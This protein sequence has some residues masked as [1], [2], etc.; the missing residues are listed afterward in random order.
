M[1]S[2]NALIILL[3]LA[4][5]VAVEFHD[6]GWLFASTPYGP[7]PDEI[8]PTLNFDGTL[9]LTIDSTAK[10]K[11]IFKL[12]TV[13]DTPT[14]ESYQV[15]FDA[16]VNAPNID[17]DYGR[18]FGAGEKEN[19][20][21]PNLFAFAYD[22]ENATL[23]KPP[24]SMT[25]FSFYDKYNSLCHVHL[26]CN[27]V[28]AQDKA[29]DFYCTSPGPT[30]IYSGWVYDAKNFGNGVKENDVTAEAFQDSDWKTIH[31]YI[32][33]GECAANRTTLMIMGADTLGDKPYTWEIRNV[34]LVTDKEIPLPLDY[35]YVRQSDG[36]YTRLEKPAYCGDGEKAGTEECDGTDGVTAGWECTSACKLVPKCGDNMIVGSEVCDGTAHTVGFTCAS[37]CSKEIPV[38]GDNMVVGDEVCDGTATPTGFACSADCKTMSPICGD[39]IVVG[40]EECD[41]NNGTKAGYN[42]TSKC[43]LY[44]VLSPKEQKAMDKLAELIGESSV[45]VPSTAKMT[46]PKG[47]YSSEDFKDQAILNNRT[48]D[49]NVSFCTTGTTACEERY[50]MIEDAMATPTGMSPTDDLKGIV[51][52]Y[53]AEANNSTTYYIGFKGGTGLLPYIEM[54]TTMWIIV[55]VIGLLA[56]GALVLLLFLLGGYIYY[57]KK[58]GIQFKKLFK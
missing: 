15:E 24:I 43:T 53:K 56:L 25:T 4:S 42:C 18:D 5:A 34:R 13:Y 20:D 32:D 48:L 16:R 54:D 47:T 26:E 51:K 58:G 49:G 3:L 11:S 41:G 14:T 45:G 8:T 37:N 7:G 19:N 36:S 50:V 17:L 10:G 52:V 35:V 23:E 44:R 2:R 38:C 39:G 6:G 21:G 46:I 31:L 28:A 29:Y 27:W 9:R 40:N 22:Y 12:L 1:F 30:Y 33:A 55:G 57:S